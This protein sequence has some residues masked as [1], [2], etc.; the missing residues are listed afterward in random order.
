MDPNANLKEQ[1]G[2]L[3]WLV[4]CASAPI[5]QSRTHEFRDDR[6]SARRRLA[7]L[8]AALTDWLHRGGC[9]PDWATYPTAARYYGNL[10]K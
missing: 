9:A 2:L 6:R 8:R 10:A 7:E 5:A 4:I 3:A 1:A